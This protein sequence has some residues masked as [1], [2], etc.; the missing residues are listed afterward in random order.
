M[1]RITSDVMIHKIIESLPLQSG[2]K[3]DCRIRYFLEQQLAVLVRL[4][5]QEQMIE[6]KEIAAEV[7]DAATTTTRD[8]KKIL[9]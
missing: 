8:R 9:H 1:H 5:K 6:A 2:T 4:S 7:D 3:W